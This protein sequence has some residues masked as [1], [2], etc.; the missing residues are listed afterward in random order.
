MGLPVP[1]MTRMEGGI[2]SFHW[3]PVALVVTLLMLTLACNSLSALSTALNGIVRYSLVALR[4][5]ASG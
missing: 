2:C 4:I 5:R 3:T 1:G